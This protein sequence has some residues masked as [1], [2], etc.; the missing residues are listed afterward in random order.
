M[1]DR[2]TTALRHGTAGGMEYLAEVQ[3]AGRSGFCLRLY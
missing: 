1:A 2:D 3:C